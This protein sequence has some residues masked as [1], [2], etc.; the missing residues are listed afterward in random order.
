MT[1]STKTTKGSALLFL[2]FLPI[3]PPISYLGFLTLLVCFIRNHKFAQIPLN[4]YAYALLGAVFISSVFSVHRLLSFGA[5]AIFVCYFL[6][7]FMFANLRIPREKLANAI[8][9]SGIVLAGIGIV[10]YFTQSEF[11]FAHGIFRMRLLPRSSTLGNPNRFAKYLVLITPL[12]LSAFLFRKPLKRTILSLVFLPLSFLSLWITGSLAGMLGAFVGI[13]IVLLGRNKWIAL[14]IF[15][16][17][18]G[19]YSLNHKKLNKLTLPRSTRVRIYTLK[20]IVPQMFKAR[21]VTGCGLGTYRKVAPKYDKEKHGLHYH[22]HN[23]YA[24]YLCETGILGLIAFLAFLFMFFYYSVRSLRTRSTDNQNRWI[25]LGGMASIAGLMVHGVAETCI[26][27]LPIGLFF[28]TLIGITTGASCRGEQ[29]FA[30]TG[31]FSDETLMAT[32]RHNKRDENNS[33]L[34][35]RLRPRKRSCVRG[36]P[37]EHGAEVYLQVNPRSPELQP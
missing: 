17:G 29:P 4:R 34:A 21:P 3:F 35:H 31:T 26:D 10:L 9:L 12:A 33:P 1:R 36:R 20:H 24:H 30:R 16:C 18:I 25:I 27:Y 19:F 23:M 15:L 8:I 11:V 2:L 6:S 28:F 37:Q 22:A 5:F 13:L 32:N 7:Y 14:L